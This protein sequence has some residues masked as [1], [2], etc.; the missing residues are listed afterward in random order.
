MSNKDQK[1][2][3]PWIGVGSEKYN[4]V[5][6]AIETG[7]IEK[8]DQSKL[9]EA[10]RILAA[11]HSHHVGQDQT[12]AALL[13]HNLQLARTMEHID[14]SNR[15]VQWLVIALAIIA[16]GVSGV[17]TYFTI[18]PRQG[19]T[20][21][22]KVVPTT[23]SSRAPMATELFNLRSK[24]EELAQKLDADMLHGD[25]LAQDHTS[26]YSL[27]DNR[28]YVELDV[29][30]IDKFEDNNSRYLY[31]GQT[32]D[33]LAWIT[34]KHGKTSAYANGTISSEEA[35]AVIF[36]AALSDERKP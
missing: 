13:I 7:E 3:S 18:N 33:L 11:F 34:H 29:H 16:I 35:A 28:C 1:P 5:F 20:N 12:A 6:T 8:F 9:V 32:R 22:G 36:E 14:R 24:C 4:A 27:A 15:F 23:I 21:N 10:A 2:F 17:Q 19:S 30:S 31:D 26:H 25:A